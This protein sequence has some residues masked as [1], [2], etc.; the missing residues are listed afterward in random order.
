[1]ACVRDPSLGCDNPSTLA[2]VGKDFDY[3]GHIVAFCPNCSV[4]PNWY[5]WLQPS[6]DK[7]RRIGIQIGA[8]TQNIR[9]E[10]I[11]IDQNI[12]VGVHDCWGCSTIIIF[13]KT[14]SI[15]LENRISINAYFLVIY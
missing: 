13:I 10:L 8:M 3:R 5:R 6:W 14:I 7:N 11:I 1:M 9:E 2:I 15:F 4:L 12:L